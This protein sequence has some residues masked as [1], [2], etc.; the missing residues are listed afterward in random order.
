MTYETLKATRHVSCP[1]LAQI[2]NVCLFN[3][4]VPDSWKGALIH[5][6]PKKDNVP[7]DPSTWRDISLLPTVYKVFMKCLLA[8]ILPWLTEN[9]ILSS[10]QKAYIS[11][12]GMNEHVFCLKTGIDD[13]K[14]DSSKFYA[15]FLDFRDAFGTLPHNVMLH[16]L[17]EV[18]LPQTYID[19][20]ANVYKTFYIQV[21]CGQTLTDPIPLEIGI[22]TSCP[23]SAVNFILAINH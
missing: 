12:Q 9:G 23:W 13:F 8:R 14:H 2:F 21:I 15:V 6:I 5:R 17:K 22:K 1:M 3:S 7:D 4:R 16:A 19:I 11:R 18:N 20:I 10:C